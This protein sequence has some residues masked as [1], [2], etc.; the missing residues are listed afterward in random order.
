LCGAALAAEATGAAVPA[1]QPSDAW[2]KPGL[3]IRPSSF[4]RVVGLSRGRQ[5]GLDGEYVFAFGVAAGIVVSI[6]TVL[7]CLGLVSLRAMRTNCYLPPRLT[8]KEIG[9]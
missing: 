5:H 4:E 6:I 9:W 7:A 8:G 1:T 3:L 2:P